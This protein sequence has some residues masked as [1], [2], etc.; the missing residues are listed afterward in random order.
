MQ[1]A[2]QFPTLEHRNFIQNTPQ[3]VLEAS[4][5][6]PTAPLAGQTGTLSTV[7]KWDLP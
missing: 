3:G 1:L 7:Q 4:P 2:K 6:A 5:P